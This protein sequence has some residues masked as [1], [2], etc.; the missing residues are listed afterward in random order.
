MNK[1]NDKQHR[2]LTLVDFF[3]RLGVLWY[4][5]SLFR[6]SRSLY[7]AAI[8]LISF[9]YLA[10]SACV[11]VVFFFSA[12]NSIEWRDSCAVCT[13]KCKL[14][15]WNVKKN[16][17]QWSVAPMVLL[18]PPGFQCVHDMGAVD[19]FALLSF[20]LRSFVAHFRPRTLMCV[21]SGSLKLLAVHNVYME[22]TN[23][24]ARHKAAV[25]A[26]CTLLLR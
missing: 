24:N 23:K 22:M 11:F 25:S 7:H 10:S 18:T 20:F 2:K 15:C 3:C 8:S 6:M 9:L 1:K 26:D 17:K 12:F 4:V 14:L 21:W 19:V 5:F 16:W 13:R